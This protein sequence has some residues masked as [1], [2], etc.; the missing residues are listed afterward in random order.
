[1]HVYNIIQ[2]KEMYTSGGEL[3][4]EL[5]NGQQEGNKT[6]WVSVGTNMFMY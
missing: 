1:M 3:H 2:I 4:L 6:L 5:F